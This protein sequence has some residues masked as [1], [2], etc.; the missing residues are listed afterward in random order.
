MEKNICEAK[1]NGFIANNK[2]VRALS[3]IEKK[4]PKAFE[5]MTVERGICLCRVMLREPLFKQKAHKPFYAFVK[6]VGK[7]VVAI[8][9]VQSGGAV[10]VDKDLIVAQTEVKGNFTIK[11]VTYQLKDT[12]NG[13]KRYKVSSCARKQRRK[14]LDVQEA[15][16]LASAEARIQWLKENPEGEWL[17][18]DVLDRLGQTD[19]E[20][21]WC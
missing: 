21:E 13:F 12:M 14:R 3:E 10:V 19:F 2:A 4:D 15:E 6:H 8:V 1:L 18:S 16:A 7:E 11:G 9:D 20:D 17:D 5:G